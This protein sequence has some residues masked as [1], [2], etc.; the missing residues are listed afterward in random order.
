[1]TLKD[2][3][4]YA[5]KLFYPIRDKILFMFP[6]NHDDRSF[7]ES[8]DEIVFDLAMYLG[9]EDCYHQGDIAGTLK[10]GRLNGNNN[11]PVTYTFYARHGNGGSTVPSG[12]LAKLMKMEEIVSGVDL[13]VQGHVHDQIVYKYAPYVIDVYN[14]CIVQKTRAFSASASW[15]GYGGYGLKKGYRPTIHGSP[16]ITL[17]GRRKDIKLEI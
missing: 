8:S 11:K 14:K 13:Y 15:L 5:K 12:K 1:M 7:N 16:K 17:S 9:I 4:V 10:F 6:G 2:A 3:K